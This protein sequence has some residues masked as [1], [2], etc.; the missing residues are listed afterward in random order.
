[1][2]K[3]QDRRYSSEPVADS[4]ECHTNNMAD[5]EWAVAVCLRGAV[6]V[7]PSTEWEE[8]DREG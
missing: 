8:R 3:V 5:N 6:N 1:M 7:W 2:L 4:S